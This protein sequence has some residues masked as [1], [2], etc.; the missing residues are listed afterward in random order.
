MKYSLI[1]HSALEVAD[2]LVTSRANIGCSHFVELRAIF[3]CQTFSGNVSM[4][5]CCSQTMN[6][7][8][9]LPAL[10]SRSQ[11]V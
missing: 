6:P 10:F 4:Y 2:H 1:S 9:F 11:S 5:G 3:V 8:S 7:K